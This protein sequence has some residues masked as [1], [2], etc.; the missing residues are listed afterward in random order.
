MKNIYGETVNLTAA[1]KR[2]Y[3]AL[4]DCPKVVFRANRLH[5]VFNALVSKGLVKV[6]FATGNSTTF[7]RWM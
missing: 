7:A 6:T 1:Q 4:L 3:V 2:E 5:N